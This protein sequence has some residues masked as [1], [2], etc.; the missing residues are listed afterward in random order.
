M[1]IL[2][3]TI[4]S[5]NKE[6]IRYYKILSNKTH[7]ESSR[8][9]MLLFDLIRNNIENYDEKQASKTIYGNKKNNFYQLKNKLI[10]SI[11]K[12]I[13][14]QHSSRDTE[15][16]MSNLILLS[17]IHK[18][19]G[20]S[21]L[22][23]HYLKKAEKRAQKIESFE[24][25]STIY[26]EILKLS[27]DLISIDI[28]KYI[29]RKITNK[30]SLSL[31]QDIDITLSSVMHQIKITQNFSNNKTEISKKLNNIIKSINSEIEVEKSPKFRIRLFE[32]IS[33]VLLQENDFTSLESY[34]K[35]TY[36]EFLED[37]VF[38][39]TN[40][41]QKLMMLTYLTNCLYKNDKF[42]ESLE[43]AEELKKAMNEFDSV[44][45]KRFLFY[46]YNTLVINLSRID[47]DKALKVLL[48]AREDKTIQALPTFGAFI[49]LNMGLIYYDQKKYKLS[50]Q[51]ISR[52]ILQK[53]F[54]SLSA[55]LQLKILISE[56]I[57]RYE[58]KQIDLIEKKMS[59]IK[60]KYKRILKG[61]IRD[62][63]IISIIEK[64]IYCNNIYTDT[65][66]KEE[67]EK[68]SS[69]TS[70][71]KAENTDVINYNEWLNNIYK[72]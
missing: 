50:I 63:G 27:Y 25:L 32:A 49:Y 45:K 19:K 60:N 47:K 41:E 6:E 28:G 66:L 69:M 2:L 71:K 20:N 67:I 1:N 11:N 54:L 36:Q 3:E 12:S 61:D 53:D 51:S 15:S 65:N 64:L 14:S 33:R 29:K 24:T 35:T 22:A 34:L 10:Q 44:L 55:Q 72:R 16:S 57:V 4:Q 52:L 68:F 37:K 5:L 58:L 56:V 30:K 23:Y 13:I 43:T 46:Y 26:T 31:S 8:K 39:K 38:N 9:D 70:I 59:F 40:H 42:K 18:R 21:K 17:K 48:K 62:K 7:N